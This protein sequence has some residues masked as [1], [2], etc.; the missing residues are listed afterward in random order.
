L[1]IREVL[2]EQDKSNVGRQHDLI[3]S[4]YI[5]RVSKAAAR[6]GTHESR[7]EAEAFLRMALGLA[8]K[9]PWVDKM[10]LI[11]DLNRELQS[12]AR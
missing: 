12:L 4:L 7:S 3:V 1:Q 9:Y 10:Q 2:A 8:D 11:D 6:M 5:Y